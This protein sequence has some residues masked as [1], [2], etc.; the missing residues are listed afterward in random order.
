MVNKYEAALVLSVANGDEAVEALKA[1]FN[2]LIE[3]VFTS[4]TAEPTFPA[5]YERI[6][7]ITE[8]VLRA[9]VIKK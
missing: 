5:E 3:N 9:L 1:K 2:E 7:G 8:G 6:A 4:F